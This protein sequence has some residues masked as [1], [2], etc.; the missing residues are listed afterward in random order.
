MEFAS[1]DIT[2]LVNTSLLR[3]Q[4]VANQRRNI[5]DLIVVADKC[6]MHEITV[7]YTHETA[8]FFGE[9]VVSENP[10]HLFCG[11]LD[12]FCSS[13]D[14]DGRSISYEVDFP[15]LETSPGVST[16]TKKSILFKW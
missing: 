7:P 5:S 11:F 16:R 9:C 14:L 12:G 2:N 8:D 13:V 1:S 15:F 6:G 10:G 4:F 3:L